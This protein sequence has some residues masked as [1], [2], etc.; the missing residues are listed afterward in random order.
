MLRFA[1][2]L[3]ASLLLPASFSAAP[4]SA[5]APG[6]KPIKVSWS[7]PRIENSHVEGGVVTVDLTPDGTAS[8]ATLG[9]SASLNGFI[10]LPAGPIDLVANTP[11]AID[12]EVL[13]TPDEAGRTIGGTVHVYLNGKHLARPLT[14]SLHQTASEEEGEEPDEEE[15]DAENGEGEGV[16]S[17][18]DGEDPLEA[19]TLALLEEGSAEIVFTPNRDLTNVHLWPTPS[20]DKCLE[21]AASPSNV[22]QPDALEIDENGEILLVTAGTPV[23]IEVTLLVPPDEIGEGCGGTLHIRNVGKPPRTWPSPLNVRIGTEEEEGD[24]VVPTAAVGAASF[25]TQP[26]APG[27]IISV[28]GSGLGPTKNALFHLDEHGAIGEHAAGTMV[29]FD[30]VPARV[31]SAKNNQVNLI[32]PQELEGT[33]VELLVVRS[34]FQ[35]TSFPLPLRA[36]SPE[37][38]TLTGEGRGQVVAF[39]SDGSLNRSSNP[40][41]QGSWLI[42]FGTGGGALESPLGDG[43]VATEAI[44]LDG[45]VEIFVGGVQADV[46]Y[47]GTSPGQIGALTQFNIELS[48]GTPSGQ[49]PIK[50]VVNGVESKQKAT[51]AVK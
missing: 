4:S 49:Q 15:D 47:A 23:I 41:P 30:G 32:V 6:A 11:V 9:T 51:I 33:E 34:G 40:A 46:T 18:S 8:G 44:P 43:E 2:I 45:T 38:F 37:L 28:F 50:L 14:I 17:W 5:Q 27:Q 12:L 22:V 36:V 26:I 7:A 20:L 10:G 21:F 48:P 13:M 39:N 42:L 1:L 31:L 25:Q 29:F 19:L 24:E 16:I 3:A 35:S